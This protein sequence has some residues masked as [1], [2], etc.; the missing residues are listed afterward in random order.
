MLV[1]NIDTTRKWCDWCRDC[2][3]E[4]WCCVVMPAGCWAGQLVRGLVTR[5]NTASSRNMSVEVSC[6]I[7]RAVSVV[8]DLL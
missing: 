7:R 8:S 6:V 4:E 2:G 3:D 5:S 1:N